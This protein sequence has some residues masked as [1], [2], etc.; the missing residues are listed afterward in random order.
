MKYRFLALA[1][2]LV[3]TAVT[4][5]AYGQDAEFSIDA[6]AGILLDFD[7]G[8]ILF[9]QNGNETHIP[10]S[11]VK[12]MTMFVA[13][14]H[15]EQGRVSLEDEVIVSERAWRMGGSQ[16]FLEVGETVTVQ[17][18]LYGISVIS[19]NDACVAVAEAVAGSE[20]LFVRRMNEK[21]QEL[22][23]S[24]RFV[25]VHGLSE[26][27]QITAQDVA[28]L[29]KAYIQA[30]PDALQYHQERSFGHQPRSQS[31][32]IVQNNRNRLL[33]RYEG[34]DGLKTGF[35]SKA[36]YNLMATA[37]RDNRRLIAVVLGADSESTRENEAIRLLNYG[38]RNFELVDLSQLLPNRQERVYKGRENTVAV[39]PATPGVTIPQGAHDRVNVEIVTEQLVAP[40]RQGQQVGRVVVTY[41][42]RVLKETPLLAQ[43]DVERGNFFRVIIDSIVLFFANLTQRG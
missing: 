32:P 10:A 28:Q 9:S 19:G 35:L 3:I 22:G 29:A 42:D 4:P 20:E 5:V 14:D 18:L 24:L 25:D 31:S 21:A 8:Q 15:I 39:S 26:E 7:S 33:W 17:D 6:T 34:A 43:S 41:Q 13:L 11:L 12:V 40:I 1:L 36:G 30:H 2:V 27:N 16:M 23:L 37:S 38:F